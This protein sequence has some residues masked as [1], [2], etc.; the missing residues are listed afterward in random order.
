MIRH[1]MWGSATL[2]T[3]AAVCNGGIMQALTMSQTWTS[4]HSRFTAHLT[5]IKASYSSKM[6]V[7]NMAI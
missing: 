2:S 5:I 1:L 6:S 7:M 4:G 3:G